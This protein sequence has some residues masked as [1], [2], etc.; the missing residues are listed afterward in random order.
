[1]E[2]TDLKKYCHKNFDF[3]NRFYSLENSYI[4]IF[5]DKSFSFHINCVG[6]GGFKAQITAVF[7]MVTLKR[8]MLKIADKVP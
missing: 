8:G 2:Q 6:K 7:Q 5:C 4:C 3:Y 1:M